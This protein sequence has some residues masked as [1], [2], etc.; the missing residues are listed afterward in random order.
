MTQPSIVALPSFEESGLADTKTDPLPHFELSDDLINAMSDEEAR[1]TIE[2]LEECGM[3]SLPYPRFTLNWSLVAHF[4]SLKWSKQG[5]DE[6]IGS[7]GNVSE[8]R[9]ALPKVTVT[10]N[11][12]NGVALSPNG[13]LRATVETVVLEASG[14]SKVTDIGDKGSD[15]ILYGEML[16]LLIAALATKNVDKQISLN[17]RAERG[18]GNGKF[19]GP[20]DTIR[21]SVT[22]LDIPASLKTIDGASGRRMPVHWRRGHA[23][24]FKTKDGHVSHFIPPIL[25]NSALGPAPTSGPRYEVHA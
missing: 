9:A 12:R 13:V 1:A 3:L 10:F 19:R 16:M 4:G 6:V 23:H 11:D 2:A 21:L 5:F 14:L 25:V 8:I 20:S 22:R 18:V 24:R 7:S 17:K 15:N